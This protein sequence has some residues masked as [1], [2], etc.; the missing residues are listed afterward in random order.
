MNYL[1]AK[2]H[3]RLYNMETEIE[4]RLPVVLTHLGSPLARP[5]DLVGLCKFLKGRAK[6]ILRDHSFVARMLDTI[7]ISI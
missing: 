2:P 1:D 4:L 7:D 5:L 3:S 6:P